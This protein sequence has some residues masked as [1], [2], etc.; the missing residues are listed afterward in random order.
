MLWRAVFECSENGIPSF[1]VKIF[2]LEIKGIAVAQGT[3]K[4]ALPPVQP[5][6]GARCLMFYPY[7][8][9]QQTIHR[10]TDGNTFIAKTINTARSKRDA[11]KSYCLPASSFDIV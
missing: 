6:G 4:K 3:A 8:L 2:S 10:Y 11:I 1:K 5:V 7:N 9:H